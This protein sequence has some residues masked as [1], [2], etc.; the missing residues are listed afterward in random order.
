[1]D[2]QGQVK[3]PRCGGQR[4]EAYRHEEV[5]ENRQSLLQLQGLLFLVLPAL[6]DIEYRFLWIDC[7]SS[8]SCS[9]A[10]SFNRRD[11]RKKI[12]DGSLGLPA[13]EPLGEG[14]PGLHYF[15]LGDDAFA[16][17]PWVGKPYSQR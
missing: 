5:K 15:L 17:M 9:D 8:D 13:P 6:V 10:Q 11:L 3:Y 16:L 4:R 7:G 1:M 12:K 14:G 2:G